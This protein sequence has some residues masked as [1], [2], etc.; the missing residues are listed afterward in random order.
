MSANVTTLQSPFRP[1]VETP[2][3]DKNGQLSFGWSQFL[4]IQGQQLKTPANQPAPATNAT[5]GQNGQMAVS[6]GFLYVYDGTQNKW[7]KFAPIAF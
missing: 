1:P 5:P 6:G 4:Q 3:A 2:I 7:I